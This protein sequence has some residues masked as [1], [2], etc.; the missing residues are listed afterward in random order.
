[1]S[2]TLRINEALII[3]NRAA[4]RYDN[5][6]TEPPVFRRKIDLP[7]G[8]HEAHLEAAVKTYIGQRWAW[9]CVGQRLCLGALPLEELP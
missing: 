4:T 8:A 3:A 9:V 1:M 2:T 7:M 5:E 6:I